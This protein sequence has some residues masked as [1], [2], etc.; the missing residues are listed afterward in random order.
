MKIGIDLGGSHIGVGIVDND[1]NVISK[2]ECD[3]IKDENLEV[4]NFI[5][6]N[7]CKLINEVLKEQKLKLQDAELIG[8]A[9]PGIVENGIIVKSKNLNLKKF[10][11]VEELHKYYQLPIYIRNDGKCAAMAEKEYG[12][13]KSYSDG[14]F[15]NIGT[16]IGGAV[17]EKGKL[18]E[19]SHGMGYEVGHTIIQ[20]DGKTCSCGSKGCFEAYASIGN[21]RKEIQGRLQLSEKIT[22]KELLE[23][24]ENEEFEKQT[25]PILDEYIEYLSIG[26]ANLINIFEPEVIVIRRKLCIL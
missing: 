12:N 24:F 13:L 14:L 8:I 10:N 18:L 26:I 2:R 21:L 16:G 15:L 20:K 17:F 19:N 9:A 3:I 7:I 11:I 1:G 22:G 6:T 4:Q 23:I 5:I 25:K